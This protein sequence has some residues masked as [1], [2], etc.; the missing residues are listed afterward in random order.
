MTVAGVGEEIRLAYVSV[1]TATLF[2]LAWGALLRSTPV[3]LVFTIVA[4]LVADLALRL[5]LGDLARWFTSD[6][7]TTWLLGDE[8][9]SLAAV[10]SAAIWY[11]APLAVG[12]WLQTRWEVR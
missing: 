11:L 12:C 8:S 5:A 9:F 1:V 10:T 6:T 2:G 7:S 3:A 4:S